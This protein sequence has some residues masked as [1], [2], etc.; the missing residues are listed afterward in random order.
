MRIGKV[1]VSE[2]E[3]SLAVLV[4]NGVYLVPWPAGCRN[5]ADVLNSPD[6]QELLGRMFDAGSTLVGHSQVKLLAP[7]DR[8]EV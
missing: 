8:Q 7:I 6:P 3:E 4:E 2:N 1:Q 5:L